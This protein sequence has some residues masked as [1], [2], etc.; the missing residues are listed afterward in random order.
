MFTRANGLLLLSA[1]FW[2]MGIFL[3]VEGVRAHIG[4]CIWFVI[5]PFVV[6]YAYLNAYFK[7]K[8]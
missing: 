7:S 3:V 1:I 5:I 6:S 4:G 8:K 2:A